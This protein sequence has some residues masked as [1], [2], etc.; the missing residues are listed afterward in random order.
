MRSFR[1]QVIR[2]RTYNNVCLEEGVGYAA[3]GE[4][5]VTETDLISPDNAVWLIHNSQIFTYLAGDHDL[6]WM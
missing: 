1:F 4:Q 6:K 5:I 2:Q 3:N